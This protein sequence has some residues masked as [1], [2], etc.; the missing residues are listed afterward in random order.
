MKPIRAFFAIDIPEEIKKWLTDMVHKLQK[1]PVPHSV[2][3]SKS[4]NL[5]ITLQFLAA[6][7]IEDLEKLCFNVE[8]ELK[9]FPEFELELGN[10]E[11]FPN[12]KHPR[13]IS[14]SFFPEEDQAI[15]SKSIGEG[16]VK[17]GYD[18]EKRPF[19]SHL[20]LGRI[21]EMSHELTLTSHQEPKIK[22]FTVHDVIL[23]RSEPTHHGSIYTPLKRFY[24]QRKEAWKE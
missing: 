14:M 17:T 15:L 13:I 21:Q 6:V 5:H 11:L 16:I 12:P 3:W 24:L 20:T 18:I 4:H 8:H 2:R 9:L 10:L 1:Q 7:R 23:Y 22:S 19:R